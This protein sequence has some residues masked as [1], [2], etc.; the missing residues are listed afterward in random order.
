[1]F[2]LS[3]LV[4]IFILTGCA[5]TQFG[6]FV[7]HNDEAHNKSIASDVTGQLIQLYPPASTQFNM[8]HPTVDSL[9]DALVDNLRAGGYAIHEHKKSNLNKSADTPTSDGMTLG[10]VFDQMDGLYRLTVFVDQ[11]VL[12]R[13]YFFNEST[14]NPA[15]YWVRKE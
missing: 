10:Y 12:T 7:A 11:H 14:I 9:G 15:G 2:R 4:L 5:T 6:N 1:M 13:A 8:Q 3:M